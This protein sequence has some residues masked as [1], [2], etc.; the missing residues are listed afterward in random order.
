MVLNSFPFCNLLPA[1]GL[2]LPGSGLLPPRQ[3]H[4]AKG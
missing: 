2:A 1:A 3:M 4:V